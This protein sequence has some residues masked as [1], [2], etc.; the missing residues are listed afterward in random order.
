MA[1]APFPDVRPPSGLAIQTVASIASQPWRNGGGTT[2]PL[3]EAANGDWRVSLADVARD[4]PYSP[5]PGMD[6]QSLVIKGA[7][8]TLRNGTDTVA[9]KPGQ[10]AGYEGEIVWQATL[11]DGPVVA[12]NTM[13]KRDRLAHR[14]PDPP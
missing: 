4:G 11:C 2:R 10:P 6:R 8:V 3:A 13:V 1:S 9:I 12:L 14:P 5:F 7:G